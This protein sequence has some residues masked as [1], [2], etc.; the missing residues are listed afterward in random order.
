VPDNVNHLHWSQANREN[1][2]Q[3][4]DWR[5]GC[6][7]GRFMK[8]TDAFIAEH[9]V[10]YAQLDYLE[11]AIPA[12]RTVGEVKVMAGL[13]EAALVPHAAAED[14]F[15]FNGLEP[16][17]DQMGKLEKV[18]HEHDAI[19]KGLTVVKHAR[20]KKDAQRQL[21]AV[22]HLTRKEF[23]LEDRVLFRLAEELLHEQTLHRLG[24]SWAKQRLVPSR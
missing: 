14:E 12:A 1:S 22:V 24:K 11:H 21:L 18:Q 10:I 17:L 23:D 13:L 9:A 19:C 16:G 5:A 4:E 2:D 6:E 3:D 8:I 15:L 20:T 7:P